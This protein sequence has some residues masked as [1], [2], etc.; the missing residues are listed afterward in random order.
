MSK[1]NFGNKENTP[2][3]E[4]T[5]QVRDKDGNPTGNTKTFGSG[6]GSEVSSWYQN[7]SP[8]KKK[9]KRKRKRSTPSSNNQDSK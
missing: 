6:K 4:I 3:I 1:L 2:K 8:A 7:Q 5:L 9:R